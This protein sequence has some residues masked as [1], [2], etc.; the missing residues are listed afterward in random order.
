MKYLEN[1]RIISQ[2]EISPGI[3]DL[4]LQTADIAGIS[5]PGQFVMV[6]PQDGKRI[7]PRPISICG[8]DPDRGTLRLVYRVTGSNTGTEEF[9]GYG[10]GDTVR[11]SGPM[12]NGFDT[13]IPAEETVLIAGGGIGIPPMLFTARHLKCKKIIVLGYRSDTFLAREFGQSGDVF[14]A[15]EDGS[16]G[17]PGNVLDAIRENGLKADRVYACGPK[18]M[19]KAL[20][21]WAEENGIPCLLSLEERMAC[22]IGACLSCVCASRETDAHTNV[23]NKRI[24]KDGPVFLS[25]E[26]EL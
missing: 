20:A 26:V 11:I 22:G 19:L 1:C 14:I 12:G 3:F 5:R 6:Y 18:P 9:S 4:N 23:R 8:A 13:D 21:S 15:T 2:E 7:L 16:H 10:S 17:T 25:T 24:C